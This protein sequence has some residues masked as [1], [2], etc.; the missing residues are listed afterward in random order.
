[1][2]VSIPDILFILL[3]FQL[4]FLSFFLFTNN[5]GK[6]VSNILLGSFFLCICLNL[7]DV[8]LLMTKVYYSNTSFA[9]WGSCLP[10][11]FGP[12]LFL[13]TQS[14]LYK[15][16]SFSGKKMKHFLPFII[17]FTL[18]ELTYLLQPRNIRE[19]ILNNIV[20]S[21]LP[22]AAYLVSLLIFMQFLFYVFASLRLIG[23][24]KKAASENFSNSR[25]INVSWLYSTMV[26]F[27]LIMF[28]STVN[29]LLSLTFWAKYYF[30][31]LNLIVFAVLMFI[32]QVLLKA[33][34]RPYFFSFS[35]NSD[36]IDSLPIALRSGS[37]GPESAEKEKILQQIL[38]YM[39]DRKP[40]LEPELTLD[41]LAAQLSIRP[42][43]LS[44]LINEKLQQNF[45][46]FIN[47]YRIEEAGRL[48]I[49]PVDKKI[50]ILEVL[51]EV[52]FNSKSSFNTLFKKYTGLTPSEFKKKN[53]SD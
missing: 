45:F 17:F 52:G 37:S 26:F 8:F 28:L 23:K 24:Y 21:R 19:N 4:L 11:L 34:R 44:Q 36:N 35:E 39:R 31:A 9:L 42:K 33:L 18:T 3:I 1:M 27:M 22:R 15:D 50:T 6:R 40:W 16:F 51:Y 41:Q 29:G 20:D 48:L 25:Y 10:L 13:Y 12:I 32:N 2:T 30:L 5:K 14:V 53:Q 47:R 7:V 46:D 43:I 49:N 38:Q